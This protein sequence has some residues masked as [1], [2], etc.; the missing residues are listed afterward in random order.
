M[1][2]PS[3]DFD[4]P[5]GTRN[6]GDVYS[7]VGTTWLNKI[8]WGAIIAGLVISLVTLLVLNLLGVGIG[9]A[10]IDPATEQNPM[11]GLGTGAIIWWVISNLIAIFAGAFIAAKLAGIPIGSLGMIHGVLSW[12]AFTLVT[13]WLL[14]TTVGSIISGVG[15]VISQTLS[16]VGSG[17]EN[18]ISNQGQQN[19]TAQ[20]QNQQQQPST[21]SLSQVSSEVQQILRQTDDPALQPDSIKET[22]QQSIQNARQE[23][24]DEQ[25]SDQEIQSMVQQLLNKSQNLTQEINRDDVANVV[26]ARTDLSQQ[27]A[28]NVTDAVFRNLQ[29]AQQQ[30]QQLQAQAKQQAEQTAQKT[31]EATSSAAIWSFVAL[32]LGAITAVAGGK[33]GTPKTDVVHQQRDT[34]NY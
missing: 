26:A 13:F 20:S 31:A 19:Q 23:L 30:L 22:A 34:V 18:V 5:T 11:S 2:H 21:L 15:S 29:Q 17:I 9:L 8:S 32:L 6:T 7:R 16:T 1:A 4:R 14:T 24:R 10:A 33:V 28:S 27:E 3:N 25:I 12:C